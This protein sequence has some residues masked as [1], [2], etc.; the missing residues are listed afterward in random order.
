MR[1]DEVAL[2]RGPEEISITTTD[3][4]TVGG[5]WAPLR[6]LEGQWRAP[7]RPEERKE[8]SGSNKLGPLTAPLN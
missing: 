3:A 8:W 5:D 6:R 1:N 4:A 2:A 7:Q